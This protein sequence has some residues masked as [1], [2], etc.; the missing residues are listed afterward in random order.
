VQTDYPNDPAGRD[1]WI[2]SRRGPK[3]AVDAQRPYAFFSEEERSASG[4]LTSVA[5]VLLT[6]RECPWKCV[7][8]D[9]WKNTLEAP[10]PPGAIPAQI[11]F[12]LERLAAGS[13]QQ[14]KLYNSGSFFDAGAIPEGDHPAI[15]ERARRFG[16]LI[17]ECHPS[18]VGDRVARFRDLLG[19]RTTLEVAMGLE[20]A[21]P[22]RLGKLHKRMSLEAY[23]RA[24]DYLRRQGVSSRAFILVR[25][26]F[27]ASE[28]E[29][30]EAA[31]RSLDFAFS[32]GAAVAV[33]IPV[34][35]GNGALEALARRGL[36]AP[37]RL[38]T[39]EAAAAYGLEL[40]AGRVFADVWD[41]RLFACARC[42][43][44]RK[45]RLE[46]MNRAQLAPAPIACDCGR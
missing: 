17:V 27:V 18:L 40:R 1:Q 3:N 45:A 29:A 26:P 28:A 5:T 16:H 20:I 35:G 6:N 46:T 13:P 39:L 21:Q 37:P 2:V 22:G 36:F 23:A 24:L 10:V 7:Y 30:L 43:G 8:C 31:K 33:L 32:H 44:P 9:L 11:D 19:S 42:V 25:P 41:L 38:A 14:L 4:A 12:A 34:R 15:A